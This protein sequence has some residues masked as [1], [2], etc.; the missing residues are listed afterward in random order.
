MSV[1]SQ[2]LS[3]LKQKQQTCSFLVLVTLLPLRGDLSE[4]L[5]GS[6]Q[7]S[8]EVNSFAG[9]EHNPSN[10]SHLETFSRAAFIFLKKQSVPHLLLKSRIQ[11]C[12][13][14]GYLLV[15][16]EMLVCP[17]MVCFSSF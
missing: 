14:I 11:R 6:F 7:G 13:K 9:Q 16:R 3:E 5:P 4:S 1:Y 2:I 15:P 12:Y 17:E 10:G 8:Q